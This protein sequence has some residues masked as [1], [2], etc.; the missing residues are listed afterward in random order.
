MPTTTEKKNKLIESYK[1]NTSNYLSIMFQQS[2]KKK[3]FMKGPG[4]RKCIISLNMS[5]IL[6]S[7]QPE[8]LPTGCGASSGS[9][10][11]RLRGTE[12]P[13]LSLYE[14]LWQMF[15]PCKLLQVLV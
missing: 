12:L 10:R 2:Q 8:P 4:V 6:T 3:S 7:G 1:V 15:V 13:T 11:S 14:A 5:T 9:T